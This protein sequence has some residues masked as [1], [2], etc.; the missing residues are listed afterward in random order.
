MDSSEASISY[1][2]IALSHT[3]SLLS[4]GVNLTGDGRL[5]LT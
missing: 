5:V 4:S 2:D 3:R 1:R